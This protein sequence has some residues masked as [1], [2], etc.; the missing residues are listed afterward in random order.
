MIKLWQNYQSK[1]DIDC[2]NYVIISPKR[3][4]IV[5]AKTTQLK[6]PEKI[7]IPSNLHIYTD[8]IVKIWI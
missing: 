3:P 1:C 6:K 7:L 5:V 2:K 8:D 4:D